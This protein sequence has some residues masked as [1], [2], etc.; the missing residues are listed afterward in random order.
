VSR[1]IA[2]WSAGAIEVTDSD[3]DSIATLYPD[4]TVA[5]AERDCVGRL[6]ALR[7]ARAIL[8]AQTE[9][10][11]AA[12]IVETDAALAAIHRAAADPSSPFVVC[13]ADA[14]ARARAEGRAGGL[15]E[16]A[17][18][19]AAVS[20]E[21]TGKGDERPNV[22]S[23]LPFIGM[24]AGAHRCHDEIAALASTPAPVVEP[25]PA[26]VALVR[27]ARLAHCFLDGCETKAGSALD[28]ALV[29]YKSI[30]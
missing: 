21:Y 13:I 7:L 19:C 22:D 23:A 9:V 12:S 3:G 10:T 4:G 18:K 26:L 28:A 17:A 16:A 24:A 14:L 30:E 6:D 11:E 25:D 1:A 5:L 29:P 15:R 8:A 27:A 20:R 2:W